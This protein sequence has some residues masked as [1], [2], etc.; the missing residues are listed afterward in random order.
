MQGF[1]DMESGIDER[2]LEKK[3]GVAKAIVRKFLLLHRIR[4]CEG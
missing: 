3:H 4:E 1:E 2:M